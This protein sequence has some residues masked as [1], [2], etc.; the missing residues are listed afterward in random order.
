M[1][2]VWAQLLLLLV[3]QAGQAQIL[4]VWQPNNS[5]IEVRQYP[6]RQEEKEILH[7]KDRVYWRFY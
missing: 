6:G 5:R 2:L 1:R 7:R 4:R 3:A